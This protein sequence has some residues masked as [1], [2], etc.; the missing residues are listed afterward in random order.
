VIRD[1]SRWAAMKPA[2]CGRIPPQRLKAATY[3][4]QAPQAPPQTGDSCPIIANHQGS[5][6]LHRLRSTLKYPTT[7]EKLLLHVIVA[8]CLVAWMV[9]ETVRGPILGEPITIVSARVTDLGGVLV[10]STLCFDQ[11]LSKSPSPSPSPSPFQKTSRISDM[12][13]SGDS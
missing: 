8:I 9:C 10:Q 6:L 2:G 7:Y 12:S 3:D 5:H 11:A 4:R 13:E 1:A